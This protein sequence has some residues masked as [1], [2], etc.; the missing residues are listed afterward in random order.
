MNVIDCS[1]NSV[2]PQAVVNE[3][4]NAKLIREL[5]EEIG[6]LRHL[7]KSEGIVVEE[8]QQNYVGSQCSLVFLHCKKWLAPYVKACITWLL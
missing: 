5:K 6:R 4:S 8:G 2:H 7:L 3:D 1:V